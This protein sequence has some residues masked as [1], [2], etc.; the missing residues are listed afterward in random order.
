M[1]S[2]NISK[3]IINGFSTDYYL[4]DSNIFLEK[5]DNYTLFFIREFDNSLVGFKYNNNLYYYVKNAFDSIIGILD[6][7]NNIVA[8]YK[9][10]TWGNILSILD[11]NDNDVSNNMSHIANINPFRYRG[12]YYDK[13]TEMYY[14]G[15]RYYNPRIRR[16]ISTDNA[17]YDDVI[18]RNLYVYCYNNSVSKKDEDGRFGLFAIALTCGIINAGLK[19]VLSKI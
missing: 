8:K 19:Y 14:L 15:Y 7:S 5:N 6:T 10:D 9:Y 18:G 17:I 11:G 13:E 12:Y 3:K 2:G 16:F 1:C 4:E